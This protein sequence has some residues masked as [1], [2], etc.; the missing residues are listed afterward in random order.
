MEVVD[1]QLHSII[2]SPEAWNIS[3]EAMEEDET[4]AGRKPTTSS[5]QIK[6]LIEQVTGELD[7]RPS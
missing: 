4:A 7:W 5:R 6:A 3:D 2:S 1:S